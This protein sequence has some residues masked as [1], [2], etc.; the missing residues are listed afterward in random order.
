MLLEPVMS[1]SAAMA[2]LPAL[3]LLAA[4]CDRQSAPAGQG[5]GVAATSTAAD[6]VSPD[7]A[8]AAAAAP[9][10]AKGAVDRSHRGEPLLALAATDLDG[11]AATLATGGRPLLVN[12]WATW[13]APC[14]A[15]LP[16]LDAA[17]ADVAT[18]ALDQGEDAAKVR[19]FLKD[20]GLTRV[21]VLIDP[22]MA[23]SVRL[24]AALPTTLLY[25]AQGRE[26]WRVAGERDWSSAESRAL[27]AEAASPR[28]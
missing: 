9:R 11:K 28:R 18:V 12:L 1:S 25:D 22:E 13:C 10:P 2:C 27:V 24:G 23:A 17:A 15:E 5:N 20:R 8:P 7:E 4:G 21:R 3:L 19:A 6:A 16:T 14:V 26:V